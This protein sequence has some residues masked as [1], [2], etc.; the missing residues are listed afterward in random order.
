MK[1]IFIFF[2]AALFA[3]GAAA[4]KLDRS[5]RPKP[6]PA[7]IIKFEDP[8]IYKLPNGITVLVVH[9]H[10]LPKVSA[11]YSIDAGPIS[12]GSKVGILGLLSGMLNE[13]TTT[14]TKVQFDEAVDQMGAEVS[15]SS[16]G[17]QASALSRYFKDAFLLMAEAL[18]NPS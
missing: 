13:G 18:R 8:V 15:L 5:Q 7:P 12:E 2:I 16:G 9:T 11:S 10:R 4:Q 6:G 3:Q 14:K 1:K 17:G